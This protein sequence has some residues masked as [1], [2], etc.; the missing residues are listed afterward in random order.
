MGSRGGMFS[1]IL[2]LFRRDDRTHA[3]TRPRQREASL[4]SRWRTR[5][6]ERS[7]RRTNQRASSQPSTNPVEEERIKRLEDL[8]IALHKMQK[9]RDEL[10]SIL[11][12]YPG[13]N[14]N[15]RNNFES[16][17]LMM[18]HQEVMTDIQNMREQINRALS[19]CQHLT[20]ENDWYWS[21]TLQQKLSQGPDQDYS[22][23]RQNCPPGSL[24]VQ[25]LTTPPAC[26]S[27]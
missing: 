26:L 4:L 18:Q 16:E 9:E 7:W 1:R 6:M 21:E 22:S 27:S 11:A 12:D 14:L 17:M 13:K 24:M 3:E 19:K 2:S 10:R 23:Q 15:D 5:R 25:R 20:L 8:K